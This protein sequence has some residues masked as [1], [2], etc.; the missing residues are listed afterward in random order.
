MRGTVLGLALAVAACPPPA[1]PPPDGDGPPA[2]DRF[3]TT[4]CDPATSNPAAD[5]RIGVGYG[6]F[7]PADESAVL[8]IV[9]V[10]GA[11]FAYFSVHVRYTH[12]TDV[13]LVYRLDLAEPDQPAEAVSF[14]RFRLTLDV[15]PE[16][17][18]MVRGLAAPIEDP[19]AVSGR[20]ALLVVDVGDGLVSGHAE[21][22]ATF[23]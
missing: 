10:D 4:E 6:E 9:D 23:Q 17:G 3:E 5:V 12:L 13:C 20:R 14:D 15:D 2:P 11:T 16:G 21:S 7:T 8:P 22:H 19:A 18:G 1:E